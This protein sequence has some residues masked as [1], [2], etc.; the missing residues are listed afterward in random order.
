MG[1]A[2]EI[3]QLSA[4]IPHSLFTASGSEQR[5]GLTR[6]SKFLTRS[7]P[8]AVR[9]KDQRPLARECNSVWILRRA[10]PMWSACR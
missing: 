1:S 8:E 6:V 2:A 9:V 10:V 3:A 4:L 7:Y 5:S